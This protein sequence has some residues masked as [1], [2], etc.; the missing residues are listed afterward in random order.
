[1]EL[2]EH[3]FTTR[4]ETERERIAAEE[5]EKARVWWATDVESK[6]QEVADLQRE[7]QERDNKLA[8]AQKC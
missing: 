1:M 6:S 3:Q 7:L 5:A 8:E 2:I 4:L